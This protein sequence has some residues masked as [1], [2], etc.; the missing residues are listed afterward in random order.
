MRN[1]GLVRS[2]FCSSTLAPGRFLL[3][4]CFAFA[5]SRLRVEIFAVQLF[6]L[7]EVSFA[8]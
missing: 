3:S 5:A 8:L 2:S 1:R 7:R 4:N 6:E